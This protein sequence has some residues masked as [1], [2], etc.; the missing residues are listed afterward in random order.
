A[1]PARQDLRLVPE[2]R[3]QR[4]RLLHALSAVIGERGWLHR[5]PSVRKPPGNAA[6]PGCCRAPGAPP[7]ASGS[8][9]IPY[10]GTPPASTGSL[11]GAFPPAGGTQPRRLP[12]APA[13]A[14]RA[15]QRAGCG[16]GPGAA[17]R[18]EAGP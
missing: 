14:A 4:D 2:P 18:P 3:Q 12:A 8:L 7:G 11:D 10:F 15:P 13:V 1:L 16:A 9:G 6:R 17:R 5:A